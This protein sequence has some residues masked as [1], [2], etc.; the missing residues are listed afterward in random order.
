[1]LQNYISI[2]LRNLRKHKGFSIINIS[3]LAVGIACC[4]LLSLY[5][6]DEL[7]YEK[8]FD[9]H[10]DI[11]RVYSVIT[12]DG[13]PSSF[14][15]TSPPV[16]MGLA[17]ALPEVET[18]TRMVSPPEVDQ[19]LIR[20]QDK[21][22]YEK[23]GYLVDS[24]F[25]DI[26]SYAFREGD[27]N[28]ALDGPSSVVLSAEVADK[29]FG[30]KSALDELIVINSGSVSDT[31][32]VT[33][34]LQPI[35]EPSHVNADFY[36]CMNSRGWG[37]YISGV[38]TWAW[39]NFVQ[40]YVRLK[41]GASVANAE[42]KI[43]ALIEQHSG[44]ELKNSG[45]TKT[46][47]FQAIDDIRLYSK[48]ENNFG[49]AESGNIQYVMILGSIGVFILLIACINFMNLTTAKASQRAGEVG[50]RKSLGASRGNLIRQFLGESMAIVFIAMIVAMGLVQ[51][52]LPLFNVM[53]EKTLELTSDNLLYIIAALL[54][55]GMITGVVGGSYPAFFLSSF[56]PAKVLK[57]K[58]LSGGSSNLL[59]KSL[60]TFQ[61]V[62]SITLISSIVIIQHQMDFV[63]SKSLGFNADMNMMIP[64][65]TAESK[66]EYTTLKTTLEQMA[67]VELVSGTTALPA[68]T[69]LRDF[70]LFPQGSS[71]DRAVL[72]RN[73]WVDENYFKL[74]N[75]RMVAGREFNYTS[76]SISWSN[77][78]RKVI[79]NQASLKSM[80]I[81][82]DKAV[83]T[84]LLTEWENEVYKHEIVGVVDDFHQFSLHQE[85]RP[86]LF[87]IPAAKDDFGFLTARI[88][89]DNYR[90]VAAQ[91]EQTWKKIVP[92]TPFESGLLSDT[93]AQQY[94]S[95]EKTSQVLMVFTI[96]AIV[97]S[98]LGLYGLSIYVA[99]RKV[100]EIG[101]RKV[102]GASVTGIVGL[103]S[104]E[105]IKLVIIAFLIAIPIGYFMMQKW[106]EGFAY[107]IDLN[108]WVFLIAGTI[109]LSIAWITIG[110][111][112]IKAA[113]ANP[114][115][116]LRNE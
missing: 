45:L 8:H 97:I 58:R 86:L 112:S 6:K 92:G 15:R 96:L 77:K 98:C 43:P 64:L 1:M 41:P 53:T 104:R 2:A 61:F 10:A 55:I 42:E 70:S 113:V 71:M 7:S 16:A 63:Q 33:G 38:T 93:V 74:M 14:P 114:V 91:L 13:V 76:D 103:L 100:K 27:R 56:Q 51:V 108:V 25:F 29:I 44:A 65:R 31:F 49:M 88:G 39:Q 75:I 28:T 66:N 30:S 81:P 69:V 107:R 80:D 106:L 12:Q 11:Y 79:V 85:I 50:V 57:D 52:M 26:F 24:T 102:L 68:T 9:R 59:R 110:F 35:S 83:G 62:I 90:E 115:K 37:E 84:I 101:I 116:S 67:G 87:F 73:I 72:H 94:V 3:G 17:D 60:V 48:F 105:F 22:F 18:A 21:T 32:R 19:H 20:Y 54:F 89:R 23:A 5:I 111:E 34:V 40:T 46:M 47:H 78:N 95:D 82:L 36:M 4:V 109:S 99:E